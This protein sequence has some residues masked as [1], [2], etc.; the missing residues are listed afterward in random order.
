MT[1][2]VDGSLAIRLNALHIF[3]RKF[4]IC[5][6]LMHIKGQYLIVKDSRSLYAGIIWIAFGTTLTTVSRIC[7]IW[8]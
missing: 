5:V 3:H 4:T 6:S 2:V 7:T 8:V 1:A